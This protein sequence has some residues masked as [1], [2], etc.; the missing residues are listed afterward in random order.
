MKHKLLI[1][2][3]A[4]LLGIFCTNC[5]K[6]DVQPTNPQQTE[7][8]PNGAKW[9]FHFDRYIYTSDGDRWHVSGPVEIKD[10]TA[11]YDIVLTDPNGNKYHFK[12]T[13]QTSSQ[14]NGH[15][16]GY[17]GNVYDEEGNVVVL[18]DLLEILEIVLS[19]AENEQG[20]AILLNVLAKADTV[21]GDEE[22]DFD[23]FIN[24]LIANT[25]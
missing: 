24:F 20:E 1:I 16:S 18:P 4:V 10:T 22:I 5:T 11:H 13:T 21:F 12:G 17:T 6:E 14:N 7:T 9:K 23:T 25:Q 19:I 2:F 8:T 3:A 15:L